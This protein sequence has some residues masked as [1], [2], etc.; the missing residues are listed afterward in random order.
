MSN[1]DG[2]T[3]S[4]VQAGVGLVW[5]A[6]ARW[7][8]LAAQAGTALLGALVLH[9]PVRWSMVVVVL[10]GTA[11][12][13]AWLARE[14]SRG[15][16]RLRAAAALVVADTIGL[17]IV[18]VVAGGPL[19]PASIYFLVLITQAAF[20]HGG[21][22]AT[23]V[24]GTSTLLYALLFVLVTPELQAALAMHP[25]VARHFQGMWWAF[26]VTAALVT[27]FVVRLAS[28]VAQRDA[29]LRA[30]G[31]RLAR[32]E[33]L[34]RLATQAADAAHE[35]GTPLAT[36]ALTAGELEQALARPAFDTALAIDDVRLIR[37]ETHRC[38]VMLDEMAGRAGQPT[39]GEPALVS[40]DEII[41]RATA[42][43]PT[44]RA[45]LVEVSGESNARGVWPVDAVTRALLNVLR[46]AFDA[47]PPGAPV[48]VDVREADR[49]VVLA[50][51]DRGSGMPPDV[52][53]RLGEPFFTTKRGTGRG[54]GV[55]VARATLELIGGRLDFASEAGGGTTARIVLPREAGR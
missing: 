29:D 16:W 4:P 41:A 23:V 26:A 53:A 48:T 9:V 35:L 13:N 12:T 37:E 44:D 40:V 49:G 14:L 11:L 51:R 24:A 31:T 33:T 7:A 17:A 50:V 6:M 28:A 27:T 15:R 43:L 19:N 5:L 8:T 38:R 39:G 54:L 3:V 52:I 10:A 47:S 55:V 34:T 45:R 18:L 21:R 30:L 46:N 2:T 20:V 32:T 42:D 22:V 1:T 36:I 25:E